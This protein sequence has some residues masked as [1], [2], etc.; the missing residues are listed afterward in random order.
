MFLNKGISGAEISLIKKKDKFIVRKKANKID[1][2]T[3]LK[4]QY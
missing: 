2:S 4:N 3:R 1:V